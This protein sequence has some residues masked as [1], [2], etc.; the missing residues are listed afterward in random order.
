MLPGGFGLGFEDS[1]LGDGWQVPVF[2]FD[3]GE[4]S[5]P[6]LQRVAE[7]DDACPGQVFTHQLPQIP[8]ARHEA[9]NRRGTVRGLR[10]HQL[11][12]LLPLA[13]H[14]LDVGCVA[15]EPQDQLIQKQ[16]QPVIPERLG[17]LT[18]D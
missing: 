14:E 7:T 15:G 17:V 5:F 2:Q 8:L 4:P 13:G 9:D 11:D 12:E 18:D 16:N 3:G 6:M 1:S 10:F